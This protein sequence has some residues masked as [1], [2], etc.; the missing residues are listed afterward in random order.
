MTTK[1]TYQNRSFVKRSKH[2]I[3]RALA[4]LLLPPVAAW[5]GGVVTNCT[6]AALRTA[7]AGGGAVSFACDGTITLASTITNAVDT[8]LDAS[9]RQVT[10]SGNSAVRVFSVNTNVNFTAVNLAIAD[11]RSLGGSAILNLGGN[12][13]LVG[14]TLRSNTATVLVSNDAL[15]PPASGGAIFN[16]G[17]MVKATNCSFVGNAAMTPVFVA[18]YG[19]GQCPRVWRGYPQ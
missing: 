18:F 1:C 10:I 5:A 3:R 19:A 6:E 12:V 14:V 8:R 9:S 4:L 7:M 13:N 16:R 11:G 15:S 2:G 17:G